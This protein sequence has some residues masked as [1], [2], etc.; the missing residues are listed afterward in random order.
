MEPMNFEEDKKELS[1]LTI[2]DL[3]SKI[4]NEDIA[5]MLEVAFSTELLEKLGTKFNGVK[6]SNDH[7]NPPVEN[8]IDIFPLATQAESRRRDQI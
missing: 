3:K 7:F 1:P 2:A 5:K 6:L 4:G 8:V